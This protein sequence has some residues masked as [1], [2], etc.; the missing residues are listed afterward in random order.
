MELQSSTSA[1]EQQH[2]FV[3]WGVG[4]KKNLP[5]DDSI[6]PVVRST[7][8]GLMVAIVDAN[9]RGEKPVTAAKNAAAVLE[10]WTHQSLTDVLNRVDKAV[11]GTTGVAI[12]IAMI[13]LHAHTITWAG[14]GNVQGLLFHRSPA[15]NPRYANLD[16]VPGLVGTPSFRSREMSQPVKPGD[17]LIFA[18]DGLAANFIEALP[19]D[20]RPRVVADQLLA[21][22]AQ[23]SRDT[24]IIVVRYLGSDGGQ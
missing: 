24:V 23:E 7:P 10:E 13:G 19:I 14:V 20:G 21:S 11:R 15:A 5:G 9:G 16:L 17:L 22:Y 12:N 4:K 8:S 6:L 3:E 18:S 1:H 2:S